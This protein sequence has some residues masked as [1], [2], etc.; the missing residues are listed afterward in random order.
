MKPAFASWAN[1]IEN[2]NL[3]YAILRSKKRFHSLR[4][5]TLESG[6]EEIER[7][8]QQ[9]KEQ[10]EAASV[11]GAHRT[12]SMESV[13]SPTSHRAPSLSDVPEEHGAFAIGD[14]DDDSENEPTPNS[15][16]ARLSRA[17]TR[18]VNSSRAGSV[19]SVADETVPL[20]L[21]GM[22]EKARGKMPVGAPSFS[23]TNSIS[24][25]HSLT[26]TVTNGGSFGNFQPTAEWVRHTHDRC[27]DSKTNKCID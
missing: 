8:S 25:L 23:R 5:F 2:P 6:Q 18:S 4:E 16:Q 14:D 13:R 24:S 3:V 1:F 26:P 20:Q 10:Q 11:R 12:N 22:S 7:L 19:S 15:P 17:P 9:R 27:T 21:R